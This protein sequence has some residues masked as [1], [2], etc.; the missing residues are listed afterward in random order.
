MTQAFS[1]FLQEAQKAKEG[2]SNDGK[3]MAHDQLVQHLGATRTKAMMN[4]PWYKKHVA[5]YDVGYR[6][7]INHLGNH[8]VEAYPFLRDVDR[9]PHGIK[10][11]KS[12]HF[13]FHKHRVADVHHF[14]QA[15]G[16]S[17]PKSRWEYKDSYVKEE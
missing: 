15:S 9:T 7:Q 5:G 6:H 13:V 14:K 1:D 12:L 17:E 8:V 3:P 10:P 11:P 4:H 16:P 2:F